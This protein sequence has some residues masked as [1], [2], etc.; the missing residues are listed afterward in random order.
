MIVSL[1]SRGRAERFAQVIDEVSGGRRHGRSAGDEDLERLVSLTRRVSD[2]PMTVE[3][4]P[5]FREGLRAVLMATIEREGIGATALPPETDPDVESPRMAAA[6]AAER[7]RAGRRTRVFGAV[8]A[9]LA[10][11]A[12]GLSGVSLA[13]GNALPGDALYGFKR[14]TE[15]AKAALSGSDISRGQLYLD[16]A[17][18]R[19]DEARGVADNPAN[20]S[21]VLDDMDQE[22]RQG[23]ALLTSTA[24]Q[25]QDGAAL[26]VIDAFVADQRRAIAQLG[27]EVKGKNRSRAEA[28]DEL[29]GVVAARSAA[30]R[31]LL[32]C[33][34]E[35]A[36]KEDQFG[37]VPIAQVRC[38]AGKLT[39]LGQGGPPSG[40]K[41]G[42]A[43]R[44]SPSTHPTKSVPTTPQRPVTDGTVA[45]P[46]TP[47][48]PAPGD[49]LG[50]PQDVLPSSAG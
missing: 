9:S 13:S 12:L 44:T 20:F 8:V 19:R 14:S 31:P 26:D 36:D 41:S 1:F 43:K 24:I 38:D 16:F 40:S 21:Q 47:T 37:P 33:G 48:G 35:A 46:D 29:L 42:D 7:R 25:R 39:E 32:P 27:G 3:S 11:G 6:R 18:T 10:A 49:L 2:L 34:P 23:V 30:L 17:R 4:H 45:T 15:R 5:E 50:V 28:S 22:T